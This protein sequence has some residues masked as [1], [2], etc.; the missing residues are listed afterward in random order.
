MRKWE[1]LL[2]LLDMTKGFPDIEGCLMHNILAN[3]HPDI[4]TLWFYR[5]SDDLSYI[6]NAHVV[7]LGA[8]IDRANVTID[9]FFPELTS[10]LETKE[11]IDGSI[12]T[13]LSLTF[14]EG[15]MSFLYENAFH[16]WRYQPMGKIAQESS[17]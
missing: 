8:S 16:F 11:S 6:E 17:K 15:E 1:Q 14:R 7:L 13:R 3:L 4:T 9:P 10:F 12:L 5:N 2:R